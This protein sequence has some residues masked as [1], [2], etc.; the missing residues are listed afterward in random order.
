MLFL[1]SKCCL[2]TRCHTWILFTLNRLVW[3]A[4]EGEI[5]RMAHRVSSTIGLEYI[6]NNNLWWWVSS[7][8]ISTHPTTIGR[9]NT[10]FV[11][12]NPFVWVPTTLVYPTVSVVVELD[13]SLAKG[14]QLVWR[15]RDQPSNH[16]IPLSHQ[17]L[18]TRQ[19]PINPESPWLINLDM[20]QWFIHPSRPS[21]FL[22]SWRM[23]YYRDHVVL[24][25]C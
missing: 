7:L 25:F 18:S 21:L 13:T 9:R 14:I 6:R 19:I 24:V 12:G 5:W 15:S 10:S 23:S 20:M 4:T 11:Y 1:P 3:I 16:L 17:L 2:T 8:R 22:L